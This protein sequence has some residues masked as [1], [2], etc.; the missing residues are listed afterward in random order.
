M[1]TRIT[2]Q[3]GG[4]TARVYPWGNLQT[5]GE[6]TAIF[7]EPFDGT[8][9]DTVDRWGAAVV[10]GAGAVA[11]SN[12]GASLTVGTG[13]SSAVAINTIEKF[14]NVGASFIQYATI[15]TMEAGS[16]LTGL[17][18]V[19]VHAFFGQGTPNGSY[20]ANTPLNDAVGFERTIDGKFRASIYRGTTR[21][22]TTELT[23]YVLDGAPHLVA[24]AS[25]GDTKYFFLD[26]LETP[27]ATVKV[28]GPANLNLPIRVSMIN[29]T[30][31]PSVGPTFNITGVQVLD[32][33]N[34]YP[35]GF[36]GNTVARLRSP[37]VFKS[38]NAVAVG[39]EVTIWTPASGKKFR[40]MGFVLTSGTAGGTV[41][42]KDNTAGTT[43]LQIPLSTVGA[44]VVSPPM[45]NGIL[46]ATANNVLTAT[47]VATQT[48]SGYVFGTEE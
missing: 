15:I 6:G 48:I 12:G 13:V 36:N 9:L 21:I 8:T 30:T 19:N 42:L 38:L 34:N 20:T 39:S 27:I 28:V 10:A 46:S 16:T 2:G 25:R 45:G 26:D 1:S 22:Y 14:I 31:G 23:Q 7:S 43:I 35:I 33:G 47:G 18:P 29:H 40:I 44:T 5:S 24:V 17:L 37:T 3:R 4:Y 32:S 11:V 41:A